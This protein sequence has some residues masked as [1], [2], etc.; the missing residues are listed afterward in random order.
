MTMLLHF[1]DSHLF[2][3]RLGVLKGIRPYDSHK[4]VLA[5]AV[6]RY[7]NVSGIVLGGDIAQDGA[8]STYGYVAEMM[9]AWD[10]PVMI[11]P[12]NHD[13]LEILIESMIPVLSQ[14]SGYSDYL[15]LDSWQ[16]ITLSTCCEGAV[17]GFIAES[18]LLR[19]QELLE[20]AP[21]KHTLIALH[22]HPVAVGSLWMDAIGLENRERLWEVISHYP[23]VKAMLCGHIHQVF[24]VE[25]NGIR[26]I[27]SPSTSVQFV[28][29]RDD[30]SMD[31]VSPGY[32][33]IE[34]R[35][36]GGIRTGVDR[37]EGFIPSDLNN[38][39]SY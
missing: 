1:S 24:D 37:I 27:G 32:R 35:E 28:P 25:F 34:L 11:S 23:Q 14:G 36:D 7:P 16:V 10:A 19:L 26:V 13:N 38:T 39:D 15:Y 22:H 3:D 21:E 31:G 2:A 4:A 17:A 18:E 20:Q 6:T 8:A 12:G 30:F 29:G 33:W 9:Q 5:H